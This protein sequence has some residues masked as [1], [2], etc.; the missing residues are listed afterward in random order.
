LFQIA[1]KL[2]HSR[3]GRHCF[4]DNTP[5]YAAEYLH[6]VTAYLKGLLHSKGISVFQADPGIEVGVTLFSKPG[7]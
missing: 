1:L 3:F 7:F 2:N 4:T 5:I 6:P